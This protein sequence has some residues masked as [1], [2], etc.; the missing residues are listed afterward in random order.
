MIG[1]TVLFVALAGWL[2][3]RIGAPPNYVADAVTLVESV[4]LRKHRAESYTELHQ[5][6]K[7]RDEDILAWAAQFYV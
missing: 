5:H 6:L 3:S 4:H 7:L 2:F 1:I